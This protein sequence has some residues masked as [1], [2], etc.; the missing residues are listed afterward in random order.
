MSEGVRG[1]SELRSS[2]GSLITSFRLSVMAASIAVRP[3]GSFYLPSALS[4]SG[5][6]TSQVLLFSPT[7]VQLQA[8]SAQN[9]LLGY[10]GTIGLALDRS[11]SLYVADG[12]NN[13]LVV[14]PA[15]ASSSSSASMASSASTPSTSAPASSSA[16][17]ARSSSSSSTGSQ[18]GGVAGDSSSTTF[19]SSVNGDPVFVGL[20]GQSFQIHG[21]DGGVYNLIS[22]AAFNLNSR[23]TFLNA[24]ACPII[25]ST[26]HRSTI[27][28][29]HPGSY[30]SAA[31]LTMASGTR[32]E[33]VAG[34][35]SEGFHRVE[36]DGQPL[37][38]GAAEGAG[39]AVWQ[40]THEVRLTV[41]RW[42]LQLENSDGFLNLRSIVVSGTLDSL[43]SHGL[44]GQT[45]APTKHSGRISA[46]EGAVD[47]YLET[48]NDLFGSQFVFNRMQA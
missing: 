10:A 14:F 41:G 32:V 42:T 20:R 36:V 24:G 34:A 1:V 22:D 15:L 9:P 31:G 39:G 18:R 13:R 48:A 43:S 8:F 30:L 6:F 35:A 29:S 37:A 2:T 23:F 7:G 46:I 44:I 19:A 3:D 45:W 21:L 40:S 47:D 16:V 26:G 33:V 11:G 5:T 4:S 17:S 27:C 38:V 28:F 25:P 12:G